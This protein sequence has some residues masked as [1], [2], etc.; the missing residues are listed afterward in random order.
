M[1]ENMYKNIIYRDSVKNIYCVDNN[2]NLIRIAYYN[3]VEN[4]LTEKLI[5][6]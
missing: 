1:T 3:N 6:Q 2:I 4:N 5:H